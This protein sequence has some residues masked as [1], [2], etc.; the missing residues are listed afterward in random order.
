MFFNRRRSTLGPAVSFLP[1]AY[2]KTMLVHVCFERKRSRHEAGPTSSFGPTWK[3]RD[4]RFRAA[5]RSIA[6]IRR[7]PIRK[8]SIYEY[9]L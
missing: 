7:T 6:D 9:T 8:A 3:S 1:R 2:L 4:V 5:V